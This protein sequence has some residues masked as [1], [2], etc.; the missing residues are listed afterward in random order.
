MRVHGW[1]APQCKHQTNKSVTY[2]VQQSLPLPP[3][4]LLQHL[5]FMPARPSSIQKCHTYSTLLSLPNSRN[6]QSLTLTLKFEAC[7]INTLPAFRRFF[8]TSN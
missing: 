8:C 6:T 5:L 3:S 4:V 2:Y 1:S 7:L